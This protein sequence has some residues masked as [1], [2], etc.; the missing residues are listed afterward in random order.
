MTTRSNAEPDFES[1]VPKGSRLVAPESNSSSDE[2]TGRGVVG[3]V[4]VMPDI[5]A[6]GASVG[7]M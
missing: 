4:A 3:S 6:F 1:V 7:V 2:T 5:I